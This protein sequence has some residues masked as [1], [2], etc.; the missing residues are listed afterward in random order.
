MDCFPNVLVQ[1]FVFQDDL[2]DNRLWLVANPYDQ[3]KKQHRVQLNE[4]TRIAS[5]IM[6]CA[7]SGKD[8]N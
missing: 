4:L 5:P 3:Q 8:K 1:V 2:F 6:I 7:D